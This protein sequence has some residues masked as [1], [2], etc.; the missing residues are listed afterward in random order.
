MDFGGVVY[1]DFDEVPGVGV[2]ERR[3]VYV[4]HEVF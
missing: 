4:I 3:V 1:E 2:D